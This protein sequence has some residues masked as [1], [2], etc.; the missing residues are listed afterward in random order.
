MHTWYELWVSVTCTQDNCLCCAEMTIIWGA[1]LL[2]LSVHVC[3][4]VCALLQ[5]EAFSQDQARRLQSLL[6][7]GKLLLTPLLRLS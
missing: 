5:V 7:S 1:A 6:D 4:A 3:D 2:P